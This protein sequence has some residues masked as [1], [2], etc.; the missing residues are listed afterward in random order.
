MFFKD[1]QEVKREMPMEPSLIPKKAKVDESCE[2]ELDAISR[3][4]GLDLGKE[5][6]D[7]TD[8]KSSSDQVSIPN[9]SQHQETTQKLQ[10]ST[11][12]HGPKFLNLPIEDRQWLSKIHHNLGH[13]NCA[14][15]QA[16]LKQQGYD[17]RF[18]HGLTDF[19]CGTCHELQEPRIARPASISEP[20]DFND[21]VGCD[22]ISWTAKEGKPFSLFTVSILPQV[23]SKPH[24]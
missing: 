4:L 13:P 15:L 5:P 9:T 10:V 14:K 7:P 24:Q 21:S 12:K 8:P 17:E 6:E 1:D 11:L 23:S 3:Q 22:L 19:R 2:D 16:V 20:K 18:I